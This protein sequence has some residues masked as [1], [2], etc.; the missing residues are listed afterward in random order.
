MSEGNNTSSLSPLDDFNRQAMNKY[1]RNVNFILRFPQTFLS[2][3][4]ILANIL[5]LIIINRKSLSNTSAAVFITY[6]A[7]FDS[8]VLLS[9][10]GNLVRPRRN[11]FIH[12]SSTYLT[13]LFT[14]CAN[15]VLVII[16]LG[17]F[18]KLQNYII[19]NF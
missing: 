9:H 19:E 12:C 17:K 15:W 4:G 7:I 13:E 11:L 5:A 2:T 10:A 3:S 18:K 14:F 1:M 16:T 6:M 8:A